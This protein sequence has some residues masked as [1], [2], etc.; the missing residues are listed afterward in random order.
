MQGD[1]IAT[2]VNLQKD[3]HEG[4]D[5]SSRGKPGVG[6]LLHYHGDEVIEKPPDCPGELLSVAGLDFGENSLD[7]P[8]D[9]LVRNPRV[10]WASK[11]VTS[12]SSSCLTPLSLTSTMSR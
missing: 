10:Q 12:L 7:K 1:L 6:R 2:F 8:F 11:R 9:L 4:G 5:H 3:H